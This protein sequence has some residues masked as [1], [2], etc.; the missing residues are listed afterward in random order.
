MG[1]FHASGSWMD[2]NVFITCKGGTGDW[3]PASIKSQ[4]EIHHEKRSEDVS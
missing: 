4:K 3:L 2:E 1:I